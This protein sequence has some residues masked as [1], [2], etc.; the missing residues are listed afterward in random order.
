MLPTEGTIRMVHP[1]ELDEAT[2]SA[3]LQHLADYEITPPFPQLNRPIVR[4]SP[5]ESEALWW[6]KYQGY[7][8]NGGALKG[9]YLKAGWE[10]GSVQDGGVYSTLWKE[11]PAAGVQAVLETAGMSIG[12]EQAYNTA[13]ERLAFART[14]TIKRGSY[15]YDDL[16]ELDERI[17]KLGDVPPII[18]SEIAADL[19]TFAAAGEYTE[20]WKRKVWS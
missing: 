13:I 5:A 3:W 4:V 9:R 18:F 1:V 6:E 19:Q 17:I 15:V 20:D 16:K 8:M 2:I 7:V 12:Y 14:D 11:F 10:R